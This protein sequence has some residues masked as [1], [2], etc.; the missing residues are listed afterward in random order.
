MALLCS[1][2]LQAI[3]LGFF[4]VL[5]GTSSS[6]PCYNYSINTPGRVLNYSWGLAQKL[7][8]LFFIVVKYT[9]HKIFH[10]NLF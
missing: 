3:A 1:P 9:Y 4:S 2:I 8:C 10:F 5:R 6:A 7:L